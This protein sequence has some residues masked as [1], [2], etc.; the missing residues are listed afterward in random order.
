MAEGVR[1]GTPTIVGPRDRHGGQAHRQRHA[2]VWQADPEGLYDSQRPELKEFHMRGVFHSDA[3]GRYRIRT[4]RPVHYQI[5]TDGPVGGC[6]R[7]QAPSLAARPYS[8]QSVRQAHPPL[9]THLFDRVDEYLNSDAVFGSGLVSILTF[10][11]TP[12]RIPRREA[13]RDRPALL[14]GNLRLCAGPGAVTALFF[15]R[16]S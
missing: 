6:C 14:H 3:P 15:T 11:F 5:P 7:H 2:D 13:V 16:A 12:R 4:M 10:H 9:T 1:E 8:F